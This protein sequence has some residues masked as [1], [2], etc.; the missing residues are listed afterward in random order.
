L[1]WA[2]T[3]P[4]NTPPFVEQVRDADKPLA[5]HG[6]V[7][8]A[9]RDAPPRIESVQ[10]ES[11]AERAGVRAGQ[12]LREISGENPH[13]QAGQPQYVGRAVGTVAE[14]QAAL[15][16]LYGDG[17]TIHLKMADGGRV[18]WML[19]GP[20]PRSRPVHP[21]QVYAAIDAGLLCLFLLAYA[22][23]RRR[24]G[25]VIAWLLTLHPVSRFLLEEIRI[26][27]AGVLGTP[28][29]ISQVL[30]IGLLALA[31]ALWARLLR[32]PRGVTMGPAWHARP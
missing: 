12:V 30:S 25:E 9:D 17:T 10:A 27:E 31:I 24:D 23:F 14:A 18:T 2:V 16:D 15:L 21:T 3:F 26:D 22:P 19:A 11:P 7:L 32:R 28:L 5:L 29:S 1:P 20:P 13:R 8:A 6:L 4:W